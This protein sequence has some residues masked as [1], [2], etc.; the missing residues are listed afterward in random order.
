MLAQYAHLGRDPHAAHID[1]QS[2]DAENA[3]TTKFLDELARGE[4]I[5]VARPS[6]R[7]CDAD[8]CELYVG[9]KVL[10]FDENHLS[11]T[12]ARYVLPVYASVFGGARL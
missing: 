5:H 7:L 6:E 2:Y 11:L 8:R 3:E 12:G 9:D 10:Y 1:R 4:G